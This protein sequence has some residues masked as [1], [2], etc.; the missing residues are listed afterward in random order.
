MWGV[1]Y[2]AGRGGVEE[3]EKKAQS[4]ETSLLTCVINSP[5]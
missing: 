1:C 3:V 2:V 4:Q 5:T